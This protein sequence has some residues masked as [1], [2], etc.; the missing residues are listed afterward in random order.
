VVRRAETIG[1]SGDELLWWAETIR[2]AL[3]NSSCVCSFWHLTEIKHRVS[4]VPSL[5]VRW[6]SQVCSLL[7]PIIRV[8]LIETSTVQRATN[9]IVTV[10]LGVLRSRALD[11]HHQG[12]RGKHSGLVVFYTFVCRFSFNFLFFN[13]EYRG[14]NRAQFRSLIKRL[15]DRSVNQCLFNLW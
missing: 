12:L 4:L 10:N 7:G 6:L 14:L 13:A 3:E 11:R 2:D 1:D 9:E 8:L 15:A 5:R